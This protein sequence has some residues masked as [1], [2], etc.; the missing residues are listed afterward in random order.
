MNLAKY[1]GNRK[2]QFLLLDC[3]S[4]FLSEAVA[5]FVVNS[6][7]FVSI[8]SLAVLPETLIFVV[9]NIASMVF[10]GVYRN[11][12]KY[13]KIN[14][15]ADCIIAVTIGSGLTFLAVRLARFTSS[16][17]YSLL[18][19]LIGLISVIILRCMHSYI[20]HMKLILFFNSRI[21]YYQLLFEKFLSKTPER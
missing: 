7:P 9:F 3:L 16:D 10:F 5:F 18:S 12:W 11:I 15:F 1:I 6:L 4:L 2:V 21:I 13:A 17:I 14:E 19:Y 8:D 20:Y